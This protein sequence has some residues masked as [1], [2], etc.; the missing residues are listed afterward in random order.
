MS[1]SEVYFGKGPP[2]DGQRREVA[3]TIVHPRFSFI[4]LQNDLG[5]VE[6]VDPAPVTP[7]PLMRQPLDQ[8]WVGSM[9]RLVGFGS[10]SSTDKQAPLKRTGTAN[11]TALGQQ[12]FALQGAPSQTCLGD[13]GAP[14]L[15][16]QDGV[17]YVM[18][19]SSSG[20]AHCQE[21]GQAVRVDAFTDDFI[22]PTIAGSARPYGCQAVPDG[23]PGPSLLVLA[24]VSLRAAVRRISCAA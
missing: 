21:Y 4:G 3:R 15:H 13:S 19:V 16:E 14:A 8:A 18:G 7:L 9:V 11:V 5:L 12:K 10:T 24:L 22:L 23:A 1:P 17:E 6:L 20:D 2:A